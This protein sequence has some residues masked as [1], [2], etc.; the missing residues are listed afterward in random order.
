MLEPTV[1]TWIL[2]VFGW[3]FIFLIIDECLL[4]Q[5]LNP[6]ATNGLSQSNRDVLDNEH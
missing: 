6:K 2:I 1:V 3:G 4:I 5:T